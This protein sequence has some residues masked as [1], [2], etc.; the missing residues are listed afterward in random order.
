MKNSGIPLKK[1][2]KIAVIAPS[3]SFQEVSPLRSVAEARLAKEFGFS[4]I[5]GKHCMEQDAY[6]S[7]SIESR[8]HDLHE[9]FR[10]KTVKA[11]ICATGGF[12][13][14]ELLPY[15]DWNIIRTNPKYF[16]GSSDNSVLLN[17]IYAKTG[18]R[19]YF[20]PNYFKFGMKLGLEYMIEYLRKS[21]MSDQAYSVLPAKEWSNDKWYKDQNVRSFHT[22]NGY[23]LYHPGHGKGTIIGGNLN[24]LNLLQG[25]EYMPD[26][27]N[28]ILFIEDDDFAGDLCFGEFSRNLES[29][30]QTTPAQSIKGI[31]V[32]RFPIRAEMTDEKLSFIFGSKSYLK[33]IP[34]IFNMDFG[35][36]DPTLTFP[37]GGTA[38]IVA[39]KEKIDITIS[40]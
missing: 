22:N 2:D 5:Y 40:H 31:V 23:T 9:A 33:D 12:N 28:T 4:V 37:I 14:N 29:L 30:L 35:H 39:T 38:E 19:T 3:G 25:T 10:D 32:G 16:I 18:I 21:I 34:I 20:G 8:V 7:S 27:T 1:G 24:S 15:I 26:L 6:G 17:A 13:S 11:I 36:C